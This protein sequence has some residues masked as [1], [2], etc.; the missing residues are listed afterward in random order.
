MEPRWPQL[1][2]LWILLGITEGSCVDGSIISLEGK[3]TGLGLLKEAGLRWRCRKGPQ[4]KY[5]GTKDALAS[6]Q[7]RSGYIA[8]TTR[9]L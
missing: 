7:T 8:K 1:L 6:E 5:Y 3:I 4:K 2:L 9:L